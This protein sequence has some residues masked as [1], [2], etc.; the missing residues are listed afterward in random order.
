MKAAVLH[1]PNQPLSIEEVEID[2]PVAREVVV[3]TVASGV[4]RSDAHYVDGLYHYPAPSV[5]GH[6]AAG[7]V[8]EV[9]ELVRGLQP[10][11]HVI[12]NLSVFC[13]GCGRCLTGHPH[14]RDRCATRRAPARSSARATPH[15][16]SPAPHATCR[17]RCA[18]I[19][20]GLPSPCTTPL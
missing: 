10:G 14:L 1:G 4:C 13:G 5:L 19:Y 9:G 11:D 15:A 3:R 6:E 7:I 12:A 17:P 20:S 16:T 2:R 18:P 8:E